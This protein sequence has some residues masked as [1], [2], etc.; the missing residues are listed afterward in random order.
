MNYYDLFNG[1][2]DGL[3]S[4]HQ[5]RLHFPRDTHVISGLKRDVQLL[6]HV[7]EH[8]DSYITVFDVSHKSNIEYIEPTMSRNNK[9]T[10]FDHHEA[11][12]YSASVFFRMNL[13]TSP[14]T[15]TSLIVDDYIGGTHRAWALVGMYGDNL[16]SEIDQH[17]PGF[18]KTQLEILKTL[19][20]TL[21]Y[22]GYGVEESDLTMPPDM[23]YH[24]MKQYESPF[25]YYE[26]STSFSIIHDQMLVDQQQL[27][28]SE[29]VHESNTGK[30]ILLPDSKSSARYSG[31]Y[32][33]QLVNDNPDQAFVVLTTLDQDTY[34]VSIRAPKTTPYGAS[35]LASQF[36]T[37]GG[38]EK[39]AGINQLNKHQLPDLIE[40]FEQ[41]FG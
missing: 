32:S 26:Q 16:D 12:M 6:R 41:Q 2:A 19:G 10:W 25:D 17:N 9:I 22:N 28:Q 34:R 30:V 37:G 20:R 15:C 8:H 18:S 29:I 1:D 14:T 36:D 5:Y 7:T 11:G 24:D 33:N 39:A 23:V 31:V 3:C 21:N 4:L 27:S 40:K 13:D 38:R 35:K